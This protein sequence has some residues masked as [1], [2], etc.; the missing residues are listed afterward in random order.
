M[1]FSST[2]TRDEWTPIFARM[3]AL[4]R[5]LTP[6]FRAMGTTF[7]SITEGTFNSVGASYRPSPWP[8][9]R[10][11][12]PSILQSQNPVLSKSFHLA[13]TATGATLGNPMIYAS[14]HQFGGVIKPKT[15]KALRFFSGGRWWT[16]KKVTIPARPFFPLE[17]GGTKLTE[18]AATLIA[19]AGERAVLRIAQAT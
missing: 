18:P 13:V 15:A 12:T 8:A 17:P 2:I 10:D 5:A 4:G 14:I 9:K 7:K 11:G 16:V 19:R 3:K 6:V 1:S